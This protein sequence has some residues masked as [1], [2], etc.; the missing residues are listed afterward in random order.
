MFSRKFLLGQPFLIK[1]PALKDRE[2]RMSYQNLITNVENGI[3]WII[4]NRLDK[5][6]ALNI[7]TVNEMYKTFLEKRRTDFQG[8]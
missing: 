4:I 8:L 1:F 6:D 3:S 7:Q 2:I 5:L